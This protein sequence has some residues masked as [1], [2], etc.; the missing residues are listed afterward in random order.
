MAQLSKMS[1]DV[2]EAM[3]QVQAAQAQRAEIQ[4]KLD[5]A[6]E[7][8]AKWEERLQNAQR[9]LAEARSGTVQ[10]V[11]ALQEQLRQ[12]QLST[13][14][15]RADHSA[16]IRQHQRR[17]ED[18]ERENAELVASVTQ[19]QKEIQRLQ[20]FGNAGTGG[21]TL[22]D[23]HDYLTM[24][25]DLITVTGKYEAEKDK[26]E[27]LDRR[28]KIAER[29]ARAAQMNL[30]DE[31]RRSNATIDALSAKVA[32]LEGKLSSR[33]L[34]HPSSGPGAGFLLSSASV[35]GGGKVGEL[36]GSGGD[37]RGEAASSA[38]KAHASLTLADYEQAMKELQEHRTQSQNLSKLLLKKQGAVLELQ[39]E[40][41]A[42]KSRLIDMQAR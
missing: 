26:T 9:E 23:N 36:G 16:L 24:Q 30:D 42:L 33:K 1:E 18:L 35:D 22:S 17:Q 41:S 2:A 10:G 20:H 40:R 7:E 3:R 37:G 38:L 31:R 8:N 28:L 14:Q 4:A 27:E 39:A 19:Q 11:A 34:Q 32:E 5:A 15:M 6:N 12:M 13:E 29:E 25:Q 21:G